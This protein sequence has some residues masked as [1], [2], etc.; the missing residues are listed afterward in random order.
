[1]QERLNIL[2]TIIRMLS[3]HL[4]RFTQQTSN[5]LPRLDC[6]SVSTETMRFHRK[7]NQESR[8]WSDFFRERAHARGTSRVD[9]ELDAT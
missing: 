9:T 6:P 3:S 5:H 1:M 7:L 8:S 2:G 4:D